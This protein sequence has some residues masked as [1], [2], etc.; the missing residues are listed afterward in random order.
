[1]CHPKLVKE[2]GKLDKEHAVLTS[3]KT[4]RHTQE[5]MA[6]INMGA[7]CGQDCWECHDITKV[8]ASQVPEHQGL[9]RCI[10][11]H[12]TINKNL[13]GGMNTEPAF[14]QMQTLSAFLSMDSNLS[15]RNGTE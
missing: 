1:M 11:C 9:N 13:L 5:E 7:G 2:E 8:T 14:S 12:L 3:C 6:K 4:C 10:E 15:D